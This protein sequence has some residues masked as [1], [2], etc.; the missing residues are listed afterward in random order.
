MV[1]I[2]FETYLTYGLLTLALS[3]LGLPSTSQSG[4]LTRYAWILFLV[5]AIITGLIFKVLQPISWVWIALL[6]STSWT[7]THQRLRLVF[8]A[9]SFII[10]LL[11]SI[12][13]LT[14]QLPGFAN[15]EIIT[16]LKLSDDALP[17]D[18]YLNFDSALVG[19]FI[20]GFGQ[21]RLSG[22]S[23]WGVMLKKMMPIL[24][25]TLVVVMLLSLALGYVH[26]QP[27]WTPVFYVWIWGNLFFTCMI[28]EA[29]FRGFIQKFLV[30]CLSKIRNGHIFA[31]VITA[32]VF[33][34][35]HY[36]GG[37]KYIFLA[38]VAGV[39]YGCAYHFT[40]RIEASILT[41]LTLN[42]L[43]FIFF[44]YPALAAAF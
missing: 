11:V 39:G 4:W 24:A 44:T 3:S 1:Q 14:H 35:A 36:V 42:S 32:T 40:Q 28:E 30:L 41:H 2:S 6:G 37:P 23:E 29:F 13:L 17:Y 5:F 31:I 18:K 20:L 26:W 25:L 43:H 12:G 22:F 38:T 7:L 27:K 9:I 21:N 19:L 10:V 15:P 34:L 33:G 16:G 8:R